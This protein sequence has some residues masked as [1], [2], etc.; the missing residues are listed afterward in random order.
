MQ[1]T[2]DSGVVEKEEETSRMR[3]DCGSFSSIKNSEKQGADEVVHVTTTFK[4]VHNDTVCGY[5][6]WRTLEPVVGNGSGHY[7][8]YHI[9]NQ[10]GHTSH[11][12]S[13]VGYLS[14][15]GGEYRVDS[16]S[17]Y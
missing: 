7:Y 3:G 14:F 16:C 2:T 12:Y 9:M 1:G 4:A 5:I 10:P 15:D 8:D 13:I 11:S 17:G 6:P